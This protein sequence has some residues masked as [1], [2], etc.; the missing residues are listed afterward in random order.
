M[1]LLLVSSFSLS[2]ILLRVETGT[3]GPRNLRQKYLESQQGGYR[4]EK[5]A[6]AVA[7]DHKDL[8][9]FKS[10]LIHP[11]TSLVAHHIND[12]AIMVCWGMHN[13]LNVIFSTNIGISEHNLTI[14][15]SHSIHGIKI[16]GN[17]VIIFGNRSL[18]FYKIV[19]SEQ[20]YALQQAFNLEHNFDDYILDVSL[21]ADTHNAI[22]YVLVGFAHNFIDIY[23][24]NY[25]MECL[26]RP[27]ELSRVQCPENSCVLFSL[28]FSLVQFNSLNNEENI[29]IR[30]AS[31]TAFGKIVLWQF[32]LNVVDITMVECNINHYLVDHE[33]VVFN[34]RWSNDCTK[35]A[36]VSDDRTVRV[37]DTTLGIQ[38]Y[39][40]WGHISRVWD[41]IFIENSKKCNSLIA[42]AGEDGT[43]R[44]WNYTAKDENGCIV[45]M[46]GYSTDAWRISS[47]MKGEVLITGGN[48]GAIKSWPLSHHFESSSENKDSI[49]KSAIIPPWPVST[50]RNTGVCSIRVCHSGNWII[51]ATNAGNIW[52]I[53]ARNVNESREIEFKW[54]NLLDLGLTIVSADV[55]FQSTI[56]HNSPITQELSDS[57]ETALVLYIIVSYFK[58]AGEASIIAIYHDNI[59]GFTTKYTTWK[60]S[61][62]RIINIWC[63]H[64]YNDFNGTKYFLSSSTQGECKLWSVGETMDQSVALFHANCGT[65]NKQF[66]TSS[67][68]LKFNSH[69]LQ[70]FIGDCKGGITI[71][72]LICNGKIEYEVEKISYIPKMHTKEP[73][74]YLKSLECNDPTGFI[75]VGHDGILNIFTLNKDK[76][77]SR[78]NTHSCLPIKS[79]TN[80][81][82]SNGSLYVCGYHGNLFIIQDVTKAYQLF[83]VNGGSW[84]R[85][86]YLRILDSDSAIPKVMFV[87]STA[88]KDNTSVM[89]YV[90]TT[91]ISV[92]MT[93]PIHLGHCFLSRVGYCA[94]I[95]TRNSQKYIVIGGEEG[96]IKIVTGKTKDQKSKVLHSLSMPN[97]A[98]S[99]TLANSYSAACDTGI[100]IS[101]GSKLMYSIWLYHNGIPDIGYLDNIFCCV[102]SGTTWT[103]ATQD[104]RILSISTV[105]L[106]NG[107]FLIFFCDSRGIVS[108][109]IFDPCDNTITSKE[110]LELDDHPVLCSNII[111]LKESDEDIVAILGL[112]GDTSGNVFI[113][114]SG[115]RNGINGDS[116]LLF[117]YNAHTAGANAICST[118]QQIAPNQWHLLLCSGGDDQAI[119]V[120]SCIILMTGKNTYDIQLLALHRYESLSGSAIKG[121]K[122]FSK[123]ETLFLCNVGYDRRL[124]FWSVQAYVDYTLRSDII[125]FK[126]NGID[127]PVTI[128]DKKDT[129]LMKWANGS[130]VNVADI[131]DM[132]CD[133]SLGSVDIAVVGEGIQ[134]FSL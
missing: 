60:A 78:I 115:D 131:G 25:L 86:H 92:D 118:V 27:K 43:I 105:S 127:L 29:C 17:N 95:I 101:G 100:L 99:R 46:K 119:C 7:D 94:T 63:L 50:G 15:D 130:I 123:N 41:V 79:I 89:Q 11:V 61:D 68:L 69:E 58:P 129:L 53:D 22:Q 1:K 5:C 102:A 108:I 36:S 126:C 65:F 72:Y 125:P 54:I 24:Y 83:C 67:M 97:G 77:W 75:S 16:Q 40:G 71:F 124:Y 51:V 73:V 133:E 32:I 132:A 4:G 57:N 47:Y 93:I 6:M 76:E 18:A 12:E 42:T 14:F 23:S 37:F 10:D 3:S 30:I 84:K 107:L 26:T 38:I 122:F 81:F 62:M 96:L 112:F 110:E 120:L 104:H 55:I 88:G 114:L 85:P 87:M 64:D 82:Y 74:S 134:T 91:D 52:L 45:T 19:Q 109:N 66:A 113:T 80:A 9:V 49:F 13:I 121:V 117:R 90:S 35:I 39:V 34:I 98:S 128:V 2:Q 31:G 44:L 111:L 106:Y 59:N 103:K 116:Q 21:I 33:G 8:Q 56:F 20:K 28:S 70:L 48:D